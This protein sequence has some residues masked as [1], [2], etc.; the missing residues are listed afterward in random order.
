MGIFARE[1][2]GLLGGG[3]PNAWDRSRVYMMGAFMV[4]PR[5]ETC[6]C[7]ERL[8]DT[9]L[10]ALPVWRGIYKRFHYATDVQPPLSSVE[11]LWSFVSMFHL[12]PTSQNTIQQTRLQILAIAWF[13]KRHDPTMSLKA[14]VFRVV[15][16]RL[17]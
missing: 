16:T 4:L 5:A 15:P 10:F 3:L 2:N 12:E 1:K 7:R 13:R 8:L 9:H 14:S 17:M 6:L 11:K